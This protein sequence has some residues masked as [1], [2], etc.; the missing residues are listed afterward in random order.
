MALPSALRMALS[1]ALRPQSK[2][3]TGT[4][5]QTPLQ[6]SLISVVVI[7]GD[8]NRHQGKTRGLF[9]MSGA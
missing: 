8:V 4:P 9:I 2:V 7:M 6:R 5:A 1:P 3:Y